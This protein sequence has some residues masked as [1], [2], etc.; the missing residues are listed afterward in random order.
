MAEPIATSSESSTVVA[1]THTDALAS[2]TSA[3][4]AHTRERSTPIQVFLRILLGFAG[5]S[6]LVGFFLPWLQHEGET[7]GTMVE[8]TG[9]ALATGENLVGSPARLLFLIPGLGVALSAIS[10]GGFR[11]SGQVAVT[12]ALSLMG[13]ALFVLLQMFVQH[14]ALGLWVVAGGTFVI[15]LL[16]VM[17]WISGR[18]RKADDDTVSNT[19]S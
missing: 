3:P 16:G 19:K 5:L 6:L 13:Y 11:W 15:L 12:F 1:D 7:A 10:F 17:T 2:S 4:L 18:D 8:Q 9:L 14:T